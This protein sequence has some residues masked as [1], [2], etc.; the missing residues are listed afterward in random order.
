[1]AE[2]KSGQRCQP[3]SLNT[4]FSPIRV[5]IPAGLGYNVTARTSFG[6]VHSDLDL[7]V[8]GDFR[9]PR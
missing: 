3:I 1:M 2:V 4:S 7:T 8:S 5:A 9:R 6:R